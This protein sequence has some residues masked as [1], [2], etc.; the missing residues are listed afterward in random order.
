MRNLE[1][2]RGKPCRWVTG[3][4]LPETVT[5]LPEVAQLRNTPQQPD[6]D[7]CGVALIPEGENDAEIAPLPNPSVDTCGKCG[8]PLGSYGHETNCGG[9]SS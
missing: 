7:R 4:P 9:R 6:Q 1:D 8:W 5:L 3:E 2:K